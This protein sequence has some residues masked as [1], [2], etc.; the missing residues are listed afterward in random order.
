MFSFFKK[1]TVDA[2]MAPLRRTLEALVAHEQEMLELADKRFAEAA[3]TAATAQDARNQAK[4]AAAQGEKLS[5]L[6]L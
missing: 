3:V 2:I 5:Q 1:K 4:A 6:L